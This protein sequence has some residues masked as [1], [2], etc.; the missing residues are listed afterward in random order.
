MTCM[1]TRCSVLLPHMQVAAVSLVAEDC[2]AQQHMFLSAAA[3]ACGACNTFH[4]SPSAVLA[5]AMPHVY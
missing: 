2:T 1:G 3:D 5:M 4:S